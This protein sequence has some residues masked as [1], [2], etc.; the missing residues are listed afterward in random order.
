MNNKSIDPY[1][2]Q[3]SLNPLIEA[4]VQAFAPL[5]IYQ[6]AKKVHQ[7]KINSIF[8][9]GKGQ[10]QCTFYLLII[11]EDGA[12]ME[13][14][15]QEFA[16]QTC[17]AFKV[18]IQ[19]HPKEMLLRNSH[20]RNAYFASVLNEGKLCYA[21]PGLARL[22]PLEL[23]N[24]KKRLGRAVVHW[25]KR[26]GMAEGFFAAAEQAIE[27][28]QEYVG[29]FLLHHVTEQA[30]MGLINTFMDYHPDTRNLERLLYLCAC[31]SNLP[32]QHFL[33]TTENESL[34]KI[35]MK[36]FS[37]ARYNDGFSLAHHSI[38]RFSELVEGFVKLAN[39][40]CEAQ[41]KVL[42][43]EVDQI[44]VSKGATVHG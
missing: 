15:V 2:K 43:V 21:A 1:K 11:T 22:L 38:Y 14:R 24:T 29:L 20:H 33:G 26:K 3:E 35:M 13:N 40:L 27:C 28:G 9:D 4:L 44:K 36:S 34:L 41:F 42:Q 17:S 12:V 32:F 25:R 37:Q 30:C 8:C 23:P 31:F 7:E 5:F 39:D 6:F 16:D 19:V 18:I 10:R